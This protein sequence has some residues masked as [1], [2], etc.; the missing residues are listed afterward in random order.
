MAVTGGMEVWKQGIPLPKGKQ[1]LFVGLLYRE[2]KQWL[3][4]FDGL[5]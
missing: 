3:F 1:E 4:Q 5:F 2:N